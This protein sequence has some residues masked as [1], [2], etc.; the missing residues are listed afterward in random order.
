MDDHRRVCRYVKGERADSVEAGDEHRH[1][2]FAE[3][4]RRPATSRAVGE[5]H[6]TDTDLPIVAPER[7]PHK[8]ALPSKE[9]F[10][11]GTDFPTTI[12]LE[13]AA[14][15]IEKSSRRDIV[16]FTA[17]FVEDSPDA[18]LAAWRIRLV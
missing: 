14:P 10:S 13:G 3:P 16:D 15:L 4:A 6:T 12:G 11:A 2:S 9:R 7:R 5:L 8:Q 17:Y 18:A 1:R